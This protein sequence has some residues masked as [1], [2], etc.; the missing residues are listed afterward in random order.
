[1]AIKLG[2]LLVKKPVGITSFDVIRR[3]RRV[4]KIKQLGHTGTLDPFAEGLMQVL[5]GKATKIAQ[6]LVS[7]DKSYEAVMELGVKTDTG[8]ATGDV[9]QKDDITKIS[10]N[11]QELIQKVLS[12]K[13]QIPPKYSAIK[14]NGRKAYEMARKDQDFVI[15]PRPIKIHN[16]EIIEYEFPYIKYRALVSKGTYIRTL[17]EQIAELLNTIATTNSLK[18]LSMADVNI[19]QAISLDDI[20]TE[21]WESHL[22]PIEY[23]LD[24]PVFELNDSQYED[25]INGRE[26]I[27]NS[28]ISDN[29]LV[30]VNYKSNTCGLAE[31]SNNNIKPRKVFK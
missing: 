7:N 16:F 1:M 4:L 25:F 11:T 30:I 2:V 13:E 14:I 5:V 15:P 3:L 23:F 24:K 26:V 29:K 18:R 31:Y 22:L 21:N 19:D 12:I 10:F 17:S 28:N 8:D 9:I 6:Y 27:Y 20:T